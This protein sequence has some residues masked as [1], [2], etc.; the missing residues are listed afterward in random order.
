MERPKGEITFPSDLFDN[1][2]TQIQADVIAFAD[3]L[4]EHKRPDSPLSYVD[5]VVPKPVGK[6][7]DQIQS[8]R[9]GALLAADDAQLA[10]PSDG[11]YYPILDIR[12]SQ[13]VL[14]SVSVRVFGW[15]D[16]KYRRVEMTDSR[17]AEV[18]SYDGEIDKTREIDLTFSYIID[19]QQV[20]ESLSLHSSTATRDYVSG[21]SN[22]WASVYAETGYEGHAGDSFDDMTDADVEAFLSVVAEVLGDQPKS[23]EEVMD[24]QL[25]QVYAYADQCGVRESIEALVNAS[26]PAQALY[27]MRLQMPELGGTSIAKALKASADVSDITRAVNRLLDTWNRRFEEKSVEGD[28]SGDADVE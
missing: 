15:N 14:K 6:V 25:Q 26:W 8:T 22:I 1:E 18:A 12:K 16:E 24:D 19:D 11:S 21:S 5:F 4:L 3:V 28:T 27:H 17:R 13:G 10:I 20:V 9:F 2:T 7:Y 23:Y